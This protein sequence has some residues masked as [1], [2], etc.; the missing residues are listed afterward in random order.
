MLS[1]LGFNLYGFLEGI[2]RSFEEI[3]NQCLE[4]VSTQ[5]QDFTERE[6]IR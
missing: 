4:S 5:Y 3:D 1:C 2:F 6:D